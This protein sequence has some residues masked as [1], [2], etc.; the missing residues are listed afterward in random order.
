MVEQAQPETLLKAIG[1]TEYEA[2]AYVALLRYGTLTADKISEM[3]HIPLPR[4]YDTITELQRKGFVLV[5]KTRPKVFKA[6]P[7]A[8]AL[9]RFVETQNKHMNTQFEGLRSRVKDASDILTH[10][11]P[12]LTVSDEG[13]GIWSTQ[14]RVNIS[15]LME[16]IKQYAKKDV[17]MFS[18][19]MSW[20]WE[21]TDALR[22]MLRKGVRIRVLV[23]DPTGN[24]KTVENIRRARQLG[25]SVRIGYT[26]GLRAH[27]V[28]TKMATIINKIPLVAGVD[29]DKGYTGTDAQ[30]R[31][32]FMTV[33]NQ[34][35][36]TAL[37]ENFE[38]WWKQ[39][40]G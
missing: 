2:K 29:A 13:L 31:Y 28:D 36:V 38:T 26:G 1:L 35:L 10:I 4:V 12:E 9:D 30:F 37:R 25:L 40:K 15:K 39:L 21:S 5:S 23:K 17:S 22:G 18:G 14:K 32:E 11:E 7:A 20:I 33:D 27:V 6:V 19:D 24:P 34:P 16:D 3:A 8:T